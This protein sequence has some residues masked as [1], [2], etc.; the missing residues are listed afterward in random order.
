MFLMM[1]TL[2]DM[3]MSKFVAEDVPLFISLIDDL[4]P[5]Q[6]AERTHFPEISAALDKARTP[7]P[8][9]P[10]PP[11]LFSFNQYSPACQLP[12][13]CPFWLPHPSTASVAEVSQAG[14]VAPAR[15]WC[16]SRRRF[17]AVPTFCI[18][19]ACPWPCGACREKWLALPQVV[20]EKGLQAHPT[21][22][23]KCIQL[24]ETYL[25]RHGIMIVGPSGAGKSAIME[26]LAGAL[27]ELGQKTVLWRMN[28][29]A[30]ARLLCTR[31]S[32][33]RNHLRCL[34]RLRT[35]PL[36]G[37]TALA[38]GTVDVYAPGVMVGYCATALLGGAMLVARLLSASLSLGV[39]Q[40]SPSRSHLQA[41]LSH[42][43]LTRAACSGSGQASTAP[44][45][46][47]RMD[48]STGD[49]TDGAFAVLTILKPKNPKWGA[50]RTPLTINPKCDSPWAGAAG[51]H[52]AADV[53][54]HGRLDRRLDGR[55][56]CGAV[57]ARD[58]VQ[59]AGDLDRAGWAR[60][61]DLDREP[62]HHPGRQQGDLVHPCS[63][64]GKQASPA[65]SHAS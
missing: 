62:Q 7:A 16:S 63:P 14:S 36:P 28:P 17:P 25:V 35:S 20:A 2:R 38:V 53:W 22:L 19:R 44:Q 18:C 6:K 47:G 27:T 43:R 21:W 59:D 60:R 29:K 54:A 51:H 34:Q 50:R 26:C 3:N 31:F 57:A 48:A 32:L 1:R 24:Y 10:P 41:C 49:W 11:C 4:F 37:K 5:A 61:C 12:R 52:G 8:M 33:E 9:L 23:N 55:R 15:N 30:R 42:R 56:V 13:V 65:G 46:F 58:Q 45:M 40:V 64:R 39:V